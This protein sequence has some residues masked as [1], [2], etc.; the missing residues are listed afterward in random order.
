[1]EQK[2]FPE[3]FKFCEYYVE[4]FIKKANFDKVNMKGM[5]G[6]LQKL[7]DIVSNNFTEVNHMTYDIEYHGWHGDTAKNMHNV[8]NA[9]V[10][11]LL[12]IYVIC[13]MALGENIYDD[14]SE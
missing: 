12:E 11:R 10:K 14:W 5:Y 13:Q 8:Q 6:T 4:D 7:R 9:L 2:R 1:M 3:P